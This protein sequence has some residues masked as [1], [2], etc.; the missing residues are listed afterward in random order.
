V[1]ARRNEAR[2]GERIGANFKA[3]HERVRSAWKRESASLKT[4]NNACHVLTVSSFP[5]LTTISVKDFK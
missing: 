2:E 1:G 4:K 3:Q 5:A